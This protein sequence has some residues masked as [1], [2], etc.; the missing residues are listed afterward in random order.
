MTYATKVSTPGAFQRSCP[1]SE[2]NPRD[3]LLEHFA[4]MDFFVDWP[5]FKDKHQVEGHASP[6]R[7]G[8]QLN[9]KSKVG[10]GVSKRA[11]PTLPV[12]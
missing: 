10:R 8:S 12:T 1:F 5:P 7:L 6:N 2:V 4:N 9:D 11:K 3:V